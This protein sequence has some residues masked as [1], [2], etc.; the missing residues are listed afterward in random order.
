MEDERY[1]RLKF[2]DIVTETSQTYKPLSSELKEITFE[3]EGILIEW[4]NEIKEQGQERI[5]SDYQD[6]VIRLR[7]SLWDHKYS[8]TSRSN[9][10]V[11]QHDSVSFSILSRISLYE[12]FSDYLIDKGRCKKKDIER[13]M[14]ITPVIEGIKRLKEIKNYPP[15][16]D[17]E[18]EMWTIHIKS[19]QKWGMQIAN[20]LETIIEEIKHRY[21]EVF[22]AIKPYMVKE[23]KILPPNENDFITWFIGK[24][25][26]NMDKGNPLPSIQ[27]SDF[28]LFHADIIRAFEL[29]NMGN[30]DLSKC[31]CDFKTSIEELCIECPVTTRAKNRIETY[32]KH[33][34]NRRQIL[35]EG[36][37]IKIIDKGKDTKLK[38]LSEQERAEI[39]N[40]GTSRDRFKTNRN[41]A[42]VAICEELKF[43]QSIS[44]TNPDQL[45]QTQSIG[46]KKIP[47]ALYALYHWILIDMGIE[48]APERNEFDK[49]PK[50]KIMAIAESLYP[51]TNAQ[52]FYKEFKDMD[53]T[54]KRAFS[55][56]FG[57]DYKEKIIEISGNDSKIGNHLRDWPN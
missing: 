22:E 27:I 5:L 37:F 45:K 25:T 2:N 12:F 28:H 55:M 23:G 32:Q 26:E 46:H 33:I 51:K 15:L 13:A 17:L 35:S 16:S 7:K 50:K 14:K 52:G 48:K 41:E 53:L 29:P 34:E 4:D 3:F 56:T 30:N 57:R 10:G 20:Q 36:E 11:K 1:F 40:G 21:S 9:N 49:M 18:V 43:L 24:H 42:Y 6:V 54:K 8:H 39:I 31:E 19:V 47:A 38:E 44:G